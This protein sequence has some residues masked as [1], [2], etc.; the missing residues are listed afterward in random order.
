[1]NERI[2]IFYKEK[3]TILLQSSHKQELNVHYYIKC[4]FFCYWY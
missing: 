2:Y 1:M 3:L 4:Y